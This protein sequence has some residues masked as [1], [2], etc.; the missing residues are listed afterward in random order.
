MTPKSY[1][2]FLRIVATIP[3]V[4]LLLVICVSPRSFWSDSMSVY[5]SVVMPLVV[6]LYLFWSARD[7]IRR[8]KSPL[9]V[10][11]TFG[12]WLGGIGAGLC[13][14]VLFGVIAFTVVKLRHG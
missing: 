13:V 6:S 4:F 12:Q 1:A 8:N 2:R 11:M 7:A 14:A 10:S 9:P 3:L 5:T